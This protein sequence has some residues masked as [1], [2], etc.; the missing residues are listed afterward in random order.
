MTLWD[1]TSG[2][3]VELTIEASEGT[4]E[5]CYV[6]C[7]MAVNGVC[8]TVTE[9][10]KGEG[11]GRGTF[12]VGVAPETLRRTNLDD[13]SAGN[14]VN[15]ER[16]LPADGRCSGHFVQGHVDGTGVVLDRWSEGES[17]WLKIGPPAEVMP[18]IVEKGFIAVDGTSLTVCDV[19][20]SH[21]PQPWF[22]LML[23]AHTQ[24]CVTL[25]TRDVGDRVNIEVDVMGKYVAQAAGALIDRVNALE[26]KVKELEGQ[27]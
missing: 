20:R 9:L 8:L 15:L 21:D 1:G 4:L 18:F 11:E 24:Q 14:A 27:T 2:R 17:L 22:T 6:G 7:S 23:I 26:N 12:T 16:S 3:G 25:P 10:D 5:D 19:N 13:V